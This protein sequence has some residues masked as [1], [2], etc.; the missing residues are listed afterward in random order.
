MAH[1]LLM[2]LAG[3]NTR[4][5]NDRSQKTSR[6]QR[7]PRPNNTHRRA[8]SDRA[9]RA[10]VPSAAKILERVRE[11]LPIV[12]AMA[13]RMAVLHPIDPRE[14]VAFGNL[15]LLQAARSLHGKAGMPFRAWA[16]IR[17]RGAILDGMRCTGRV[18]RPVCSRRGDATAKAGRVSRYFAG[19]ATARDAGIV[20][21]SAD[22][23][24]GRMPSP[25]EAFLAAEQ[26]LTLRRAIARLPRLERAIIES[27]Y[28]HGK[29]LTEASRAVGTSK[30]WGGRLHAKALRRLR[31]ELSCSGGELFRK[32]AVARV[33]GEGRDNNVHGSGPRSWRVAC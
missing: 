26:Q 30:S 23:P 27:H 28:F 22:A 32:P 9:R 31:R 29:T 6:R 5:K 24:D 20:V 17:V 12:R 10:V 18:A 13:A 7:R 1:R 21:T 2:C 14:A 15:G 19:M 11:G 25:E 4:V 8:S 16:A 33:R 3:R